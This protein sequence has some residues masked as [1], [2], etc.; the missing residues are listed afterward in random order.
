MGHGDREME[1]KVLGGWEVGWK[2]DASGN[3]QRRTGGDWN[4]E[5]DGHGQ[6]EGSYG[7]VGWA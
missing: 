3:R 1:W 4:L 6:V 2:R 5:W 7:T